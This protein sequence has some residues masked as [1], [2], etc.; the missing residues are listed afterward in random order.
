MMS[1]ATDLKM[2]DLKKT[3]TPVTPMPD[4]IAK[5]GALSHIDLLEQVAK[6]LKD[7]RVRLQHSV[8]CF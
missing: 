8:N 7:S 2:S 5:E 4:D 3:K 6:E 1:P